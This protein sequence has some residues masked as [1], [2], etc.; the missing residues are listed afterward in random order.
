MSLASARIKDPTHV[1]VGLGM[2]RSLPTAGCADENTLQE[3]GFDPLTSAGVQ[4]CAQC[5]AD[6]GC[7]EKCG[8]KTWPS[9][10]WEER[11]FTIGTIETPVRDLKVVK[12][13]GKIAETADRGTD[14]A[15]LLPVQSGARSHKSIDAGTIFEIDV[16]SVRCDG[17]HHKS[18][19]ALS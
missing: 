19:I 17:T 4:S 6:S 8:P 2:F 18:G 7:G 15:T 3:R 9:R 12:F 13:D 5:R 1:A 16:T 14:P 11:S 10:L